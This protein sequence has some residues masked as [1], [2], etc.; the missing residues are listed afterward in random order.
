MLAG[1]VTGKG[2]LDLVEVPDPVPGSGQAV[3]AIA[4]CGVCGTDVHAYRSGMPY[5]PA[6]CGHEWAGTVSAV[7]SGTTG[8]TEGDRVVGAVPPACGMCVPCRAGLGAWCEHVF[9]TAIGVVPGAPAHGGFALAIAVDARR[10]VGLPD[11]VSLDDGP[12]VEPATVAVHAVRRAGAPAGAVVAVVGAGPIGALVAQAAKALG[13]G[14]VVVI[15]PSAS[16][17]ARA[18][19]LGADAAFAPG[20]EAASHLGERTGGLGADV[21]YECAGVA[22]TV[23][24]SVDLVRRGGTVLLA[25]VAETPATIVPALWVVKEVTVVGA[26]A[27]THDDF[28]IATD[29]ARSGELDLKSL[30]DRT[31]SLGELPATFEAMAAGHDDALKVVVDPMLPY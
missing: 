1:L 7:G 8:V 18:V 14:H 24:A 23:Q 17:R 6:I 15:D 13:A 5:T 29:L 19:G 26:L 25:G 11:G 31:V 9:A 27:Y 22:E 3:V 12:L 28:G 20:A 10:L 16:R 2:R 30:R 4:G 21:V